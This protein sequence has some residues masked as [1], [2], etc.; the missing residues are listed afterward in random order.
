MIF[1]L[2]NKPKFNLKRVKVKVVTKNFNLEKVT[3]KMLLTI[4][5]F[6]NIKSF[7]LYIILSLPLKMSSLLQKKL[8]TQKIAKYFLIPFSVQGLILEVAGCVL[9]VPVICILLKSNLEKLHPDLVMS[10]ILC[11]NNLI[12]SISLF[13]TSI[14]ILCGYNTI[15][16]E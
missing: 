10:G 1:Y 14:F 6:N 7:Y 13:F 16:Y 12:I 5:Y 3:G 15:V 2:K 11:F 9:T 4:Y 8:K